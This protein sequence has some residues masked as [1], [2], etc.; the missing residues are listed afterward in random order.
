MATAIDGSDIPPSS[1][2]VAAPGVHG[3]VREL[4][5]KID[6]DLTKRA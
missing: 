2:L 1:V 4:I 5:A 3:A 6:A